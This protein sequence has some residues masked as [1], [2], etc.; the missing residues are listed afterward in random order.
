MRFHRL[1]IA[2]MS[3][4]ATLPATAARAD[5]VLD[6]I[7]SD[8][9]LDA[10]TGVASAVVEVSAHGDAS[11]LAALG[12]L[13]DAG[14]TF[15]SATAPGV[16]VSMSQQL[17]APYNYAVLS[18]DPPVSPGESVPITVTY[19]GTL[20]CGEYAPGSTFCDRPAGK[21]G[22]FQTG[23]ILPYVVDPSTSQPPVA[24][25]TITVR[26]PT[27][28]KCFVG[29]NPVSEA[30]DG[31]M[32][33]SVWEVSTPVLAFT[34]IFTGAFESVSIP[35]T[36]VPIT[37][38]HSPDD[39]AW[40]PKLAS[41]T[42]SVVEFVTAKANRPLPF[43]AI[44]LIKFGAEHGDTGYTGIAHIALSDGHAD[45]G[46]EY[47]EE[48]WSHEFAHLW[49]GVTA[50]PADFALQ[51]MLTEGIVTV[52]QYDYT[53]AHAHAD[54][55]RD[56]YLARRFREAD[57]LLRYAGTPA[58]STPVVVA[59]PDDAVSPERD[60]GS[61]SFIW[62]Y[63]KAPATLDYLRVLIGEQAY[64]E[65]LS[66]YLDRCEYASCSVSDFR[67]VAE[68]TSRLDLS[69]FFA[70]YVHGSSYPEVEL[71]F[72]AD[73]VA[74]AVVVT[75]T[76]DAEHWVAL[77][78]WIELDDGSVLRHPVVFDTQTAS[79][80]IPVQGAPI[81]VRP[82]PRQETF[83][84]VRSK[85]R[86]DVTLDGDVDG[87]DV[88]HAAFL[89]GKSGEALAAGGAGSVYYDLDIAFDPRVDID[90]DGLLGDVDLQPVVENFGT[91]GA[92]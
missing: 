28:Q 48:A 62:E 13:V 91:R 31:T 17:Y 35:D 22:R 67:D 15:T 84:H 90:H 7:S 80:T 83:V 73:P 39:A 77:E 49:F 25:Q 51:K 34:S 52:V 43:E 82:N 87:L 3:L 76:Q 12:I 4:A 53:A 6:H 24:T 32:A 65:A 29:A 18:I 55:D 9:T 66:L 61:A 42:A 56:E 23:S 27:G 44:Q 37:F 38:H 58:T 88:L 2:P 36:P 68:E 1:L 69:R 10:T 54:V 50:M 64:A 85:T 11:P 45:P 33:T 14:L 57:L 26:G 70:E 41:W 19:A 20:V 21:L 16:S 81:A 72:V 60:G 5:A 92:P 30:D 78:L 79:F 47:F 8:I 74:G 63:H 46:D 71:G 59:T 75:L 40:G 89:H 86:G